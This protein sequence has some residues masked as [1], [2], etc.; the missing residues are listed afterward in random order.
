M[1]WLERHPVPAGKVAVFRDIRTTPSSYNRRHSGPTFV[2]NA[3]T[4]SSAN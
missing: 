4:F 3:N 2:Q 1:A